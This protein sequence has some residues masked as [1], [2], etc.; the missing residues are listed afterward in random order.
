[1][2]EAGLKSSVF[3]MGRRIT[4]AT[5]AQFDTGATNS[6]TYE[7]CQ[8]PGRPRLLTNKVSTSWSTWWDYEGSTDGYPC[9]AAGACPGSL[10]GDGRDLRSRLFRL[11]HYRPN[12]HTENQASVYTEKFVYL[13]HCYQINDN[14]PYVDEND[15][16]KSEFGLP[17]EAFIFCCFNTSYKIDTEI[18]STWMNIL[19]RLPGSVLWLMASSWKHEGKLKN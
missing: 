6:S 18:F 10:V 17:E 14:Q 16:K 4:V 3:H 2:T 13:P 19:R 9:N 1:M 5:A 7:N 12:C 8:M 15:C 11:P